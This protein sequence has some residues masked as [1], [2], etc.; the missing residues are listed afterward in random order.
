MYTV[1]KAKEAV[2]EAVRGYLYK[3]ADG[4][5]V[6]DEWN[7]QP[8]YLE[9]A[10][11]I[12]KTE[13]VKQVSSELGLGF[14]SFSMVHHSRNSLLGLP[15]INELKNGGKYTTYTM[16]EVIAKVLESVGE[17]NR[18]GILLLDEFPCMS[19]TLMPAM[20]A[21][22]QT[23][24][25]GM[26]YLPEGWV[27]VLCGNPPEY[28]KASKKFDASILDRIRKIEVE[29]DAQC[30]LSYG[31]EKEFAEVILSYLE[32]QPDHVYSYSSGDGETELVTCRGWENLSHAIKIYS[33]L[34]QEIDDDMVR[35]FIKSDKISSS[36]VQYYRQWQIGMTL[37]EIDD[38]LS[39]TGYE[40]YRKKLTTE[41]NFRQQWL[42][43]GYLCDRLATK[44][45]KEEVGAARY[46]EI[47]GWMGNVLDMIK[48]ID[49]KGV[50]CETAFQFINKN[51]LL[52]KVV[53]SVKVPEYLE[54]CDKFLGDV[55]E[56]VSA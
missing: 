2:K 27:I 29:F 20:L 35:Q 38:I 10:P 47:A 9:G 36:F 14:V 18:E 23:K 21:F 46:K 34:G 31:K 17:G 54:L 30:F 12:G 48:E 42:L 19:E 49:E 26:H 6:M 22:L 39:G 11:G 8:I 33:E 52:L 55:R 24:N 16:S 32:L 15:V 43:T 25:I 50:L 1:S 45:T 28:N 7:R 4:N 51:E 37:Q 44:K 3:D 13:L 41:L 40:K 5:Y 56:R 53:S